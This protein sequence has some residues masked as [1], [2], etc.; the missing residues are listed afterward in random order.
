MSINFDHNLEGYLCRIP[1]I[2]ETVVL[3]KSI[4]QPILPPPPPNQKKI[5]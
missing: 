4:E 2:F 5:K 1:L 3:S